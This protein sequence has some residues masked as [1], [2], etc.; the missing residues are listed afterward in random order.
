MDGARE[1]SL[2]LA[3]YL[4]SAAASG[5][6]VRYSVKKNIE[7]WQCKHISFIMSTFAYMPQYH[8][9]PFPYVFNLFSVCFVCLFVYSFV[10]SFG[11]HIADHFIY[12]C[13]HILSIAMCH[14]LMHH[15]LITSPAYSMRECASKRKK[16]N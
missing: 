4:C 16:E 10:R 9:S 2:S 13:V 14:S 11:P 8:N 7:S 15:K 5:V 3:R 6:S 12:L 1:R